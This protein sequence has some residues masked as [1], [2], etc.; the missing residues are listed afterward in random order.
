MKELK[1]S[2]TC[3]YCGGGNSLLKRGFR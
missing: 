1:K 2:S 3:T